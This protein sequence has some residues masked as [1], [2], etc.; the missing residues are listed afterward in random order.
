MTLAIWHDAIRAA[1]REKLIATVAGTT[2]PRPVFAWEG[3]G[4]Q[5][6][7]GSA[8]IAETFRPVASIP[9]SIGRSAGT[10]EHR[11]A[12]ALVLRYPAGKGTKPATLMAGTILAAF[13][14]GVVLVRS[15]CAATV[16][17]S[18]LAPGL[19]D[20]DWYAI[21]VNI[22]LIGHTNT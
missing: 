16:L 6:V 14:H 5:P 15:G 4:F 18:E 10:I 20:P 8:Y 21:P 7:V 9:R 3:E 22:A 11:A 13:A 17:S 1:A 12:V 2:A 19:Q